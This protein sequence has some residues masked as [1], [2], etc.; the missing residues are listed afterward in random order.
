ML[1]INSTSDIIINNTVGIIDDTSDLLTYRNMLNQAIKMNP[2]NIIVGKYYDNIKILNDMK[3]DNLDPFNDV[4]SYIDRNKLKKHMYNIN[5]SITL[6]FLH[7]FE[8]NVMKRITGTKYYVSLKYPIKENIKYVRS[9]NTVVS[10][11]NQ[12][13]YN[14]YFRM[15]VHDM[16]QIS[17]NEIMTLHYIK[18]EL[19]KHISYQFDL[20]KYIPYVKNIRNDNVD[21]HISVQYMNE[22]KNIIEDVTKWNKMD[23]YSGDIFINI[24]PNAKKVIYRKHTENQKYLVGGCHKKY[25][26]IY[27][28]T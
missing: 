27:D 9:K 28:T 18:P 25:K 10:N 14:M 20:S 13:Q 5:D 2:K 24:S 4:I 3:K 6:S 16:D 23:R 12:R 17:N 8:N 11:I 22:I 15:H 26:I 19:L 7:A 21:Y 1:Q